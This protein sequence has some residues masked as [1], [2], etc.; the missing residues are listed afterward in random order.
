MRIVY[1]AQ[2]GSIHTRRW[3]SFFAERGHEVHVVTCGG[4]DAVDL[5]A[6]GA[7]LPRPYTI[8]DLGRPRPGKLGYFLKVL[9]ARRLIKR[10][11]PDVLH[12]HF[13]TSFGMIA[14][15][16]GT[17]PLVVTAHGDDVLVAPGTRRPV[18]KLIVSAVL[19]AAS[20][21]TVPA[22]HMC[23]PVRRLLGPKSQDVPIAVFQYGV[24]V[25]R[26]ERI[27]E[28]A[29]LERAEH[30]LSG[31]GGRPLEIVCSRAMLRLY[32]IDALLDALAILARRGRSFRCHLVGD[33]PERG[34]LEAQAAALG[35]AGDV[36]FHGHVPGRR[37]EQIVAGADVYVSVSETDGVSLSLL[38][39]L[40]LGPVPVLSDIPANR[41]W[42]HDGQT[43]VLVE[44][45]A[46]AIAEGILQAST[47]DAERV[48]RDNRAVVAERADRTT[49]LA[50]CELLI[51]E[52]VGVSWDPSPAD[53]DAA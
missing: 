40:A 29:R 35:I 41:G 25:A 33:G 1:V 36:V 34:A 47:L 46:E 50:A 9:P 42:I 38:E 14:L 45:T 52:L 11:D 6:D 7:P 30:K 8:H 44:L 31:G 51:D 37:V 2:H 43:G 19:R 48:A 13:A 53:S 17:R 49:N 23:E 5:D 18:M 12:A 32:R 20:L 3:V 21:I 28:Q 22:D 15:M 10:L 24:E 27:A 26:L 16:S 39:A 4:G